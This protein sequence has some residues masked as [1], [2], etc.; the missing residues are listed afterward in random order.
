MAW[1]HRRTTSE[2]DCSL[3]S[4]LGMH[5]DEPGATAGLKVLA[6]GNFRYLVADALRAR[7]LLA[8]NEALESYSTAYRVA[9]LDL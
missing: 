6:D 1:V 4:S 3:L 7:Q 9:I 5:K 8:D 2:D